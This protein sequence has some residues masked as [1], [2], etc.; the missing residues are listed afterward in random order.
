MGLLGVNVV[1][2]AEVLERTTPPIGGVGLVFTLTIFTVWSRSTLLKRLC[3]M[4]LL[5]LSLAPCWAC[6]KCHEW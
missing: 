1:P 4:A 5:P 2:D 3:H 6:Y